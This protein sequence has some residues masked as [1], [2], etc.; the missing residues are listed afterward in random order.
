M[1]LTVNAVGGSNSYQ[2]LELFEKATTPPSRRSS[3]T[4]GTDDFSLYP[5]ILAENLNNGA[6]TVG[7]RCMV[8]PT[9]YGLRT[10][11][12]DDEGKNRVVHEFAAFGPRTQTPD[13]NRAEA[14]THPELMQA[15]DL[16]PIEAGAD[17][18]AQLIA[19]AGV[20]ACLAA[21]RGA[22]P[23]LRPSGGDP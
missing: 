11:G 23:A 22:V 20:Q 15:D 2:I 14:P 8:V 3:S 4:P 19:P 18:P 6:A 17:L 13:W 16:H 10:G 5:Q 7:N 12:V 9:I 21:L 1:K